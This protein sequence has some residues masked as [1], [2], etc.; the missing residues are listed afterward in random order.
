[1]TTKAKTQM[2][3]PGPSEFVYLSS[4]EAED[5]WH[6]ITAALGPMDG[7]YLICPKGK[8]PN[9]Y[10][11]AWDKRS[12]TLWAAAPD[13]LEVAKI[14]KLVCALSGTDD[15]QGKVELQTAILALRPKA[16]AAIRKAGGL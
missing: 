6:Q 7:R 1:M 9:S 13:L 5:K 2:H 4:G 12:A 11:I 16:G 8:A 15:P 10:G 14:A 3:T